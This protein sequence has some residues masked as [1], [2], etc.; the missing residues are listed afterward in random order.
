M[1]T[2]GVEAR[3][4]RRRLDA[5]SR[6]VCIRSVVGAALIVALASAWAGTQPLS[7]DDQAC[8]E[9][10]G[11]GPSRNAFTQARLDPLPTCER[12]EAGGH[13]DVLAWLGHAYG[14]ADRH[15]DAHRLLLRAH[16][17]GSLTG[18]ALLGVALV[19]GRGVSQDQSK[20]EELLLQA[21]VLGDSDAQ[22]ML[23]TMY[24]TG[25]LRP[26][27]KDQAKA[28]LEK[29]AEQGHAAAQTNLGALHWHPERTH[30][31]YEAA[32]AQGNA[33]A[34]YNLGDHFK[35]EC[36]D[37]VDIDRAIHYFERAAMQQLPKAMLWLARLRASGS[38]STA[39]D[40]TEAQRWLSIAKAWNDEAYV[41]WLITQ[42]IAQA[43]ADIDALAQEDPA[44]AATV[45]FHYLQWAKLRPMAWAAAA[46]Y[47]ES[48]HFRALSEPRK[49]SLLEA[50]GQSVK[51]DPPNMPRLP[52]PQERSAV[53]RL[54]SLGLRQAAEY[55]GRPPLPT[56]PAEAIS[57]A[58]EW[59]SRAAA[60]GSPVAAFRLGEHHAT[61]LGVAADRAEA[62]RW[63]RI[64]AGLGHAKAALRV[65]QAIR[66]D[67]RL[68]LAGESAEPWI[69]QAADLDDTEA[70][71][72]M[73][74]MAEAR[75][76]KDDVAQ[77]L[78]WYRKAE[79]QRPKEA[80]YRLAAVYRDGPTGLRDPDEAQLM[81]RLGDLDVPVSERPSPFALAPGTVD[82]AVRQARQHE[83]DAERQSRTHQWNAA[84]KGFRESARW[85]LAAGNVEGSVS[86]YVRNVVMLDIADG[87][88]RGS[89]DNYFFLL[90][91]SCHWSNAAE[92][93]REEGQLEAALT[94]AKHAVNLLQRARRQ[95]HQLP[96]S[97]RECFLQAHED[98][99]R[100]LAGLMVD[101]GK[102][103][104]AEQVL[105]ML[106]SFESEEYVRRAGTPRESARQEFGFNERERDLL[107][108]IDALRQ[109]AVAAAALRRLDDAE[110]TRALS[111]AEAKEREEATGTLQQARRKLRAG[112]D[113]VLAELRALRQGTAG[114]SAHEAAL[115]SAV[116]IQSSLR[117]LFGGR[118]VVIQTVVLPQRTHLLV[119]SA[120]TQQVFKV[121]ITRAELSR[122]VADLR[123]AVQARSDAALPQAQA[124]Y[125]LLLAPVEPLLQGATTL[126]ISADDVLRYLPHAMLHDGQA[127]LVE[128][129]A[130]TSYSPATR[131]IVVAAPRRKPWQVAAFGASLAQPELGFAAL[132]AVASELRA[133]VRLP[134]ESEGAMPGL[135]RMDRDFDRDT[136]AAGLRQ[137]LPALHIASHFRLAFG[138]SKGS[139]LLL[140]DGRTLSMAD[141]ADTVSYDLAHLDLLTLSACET[142]VPVGTDDA[143]GA[144]VESLSAL[145]HQAGARSVLAT[146]W[147][148]ADRGTADF[149]G[150]FY[151]YLA[152]SP[153]MGKAEALRR[154]QVDFIRGQ[155]SAS[156]GGPPRP[157]P[158]YLWAPFVLSGHWL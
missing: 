100:W 151:A 72:L 88:W 77:A 138:D 65:G 22:F 113:T 53:A 24:S 63:H 66:S 15:D 125:R 89:S 31:L 112:L 83:A 94:L 102:L 97:L 157:A 137:R 25:E 86:T 82:K 91:S 119:T 48:P 148:V 61:G 29:A 71:I 45:G 79:D 149:M 133:V 117:D 136:L 129:F 44:R 55:L 43:L 132:P 124:L 70:Q 60:Q 144:E 147:P 107:A 38:Q 120:Q 78:N 109:Q 3:W 87:L 36:T 2:Q 142:A 106:K 145:V 56:G 156:S 62:L 1:T 76:S 9:A 5:R 10:A 131:D 135:R 92:W 114:E 139:V 50:L 128:R 74:Q 20:G 111:A 4:Q 84:A 152:G 57:S 68:A 154:T 93:A 155:G 115:K 58:F 18:T 33:Q 64:A 110:A 13:P 116:S 12:A 141:L 101:L 28:W 49:S 14:K 7:P 19:R 99:Y 8:R 32:A 85:H 35:C 47:L 17:G 108:S 42:S 11:F 153:D 103:G 51:W 23:S 16:R 143:S 39:P 123:L 37:E 105:G 95:L 40:R 69:R 30:A 6:V 158:P 21:A 41:E 104:E 34:L 75:G 46:R 134:G 150:R 67:P 27:D 130:V 80:Y 140:G 54:A 122:R 26:P 127:Y 98:R 118:A 90:Q 73:G 52:D 126:M 59:N 81:Q 96:D 121:D 146:L